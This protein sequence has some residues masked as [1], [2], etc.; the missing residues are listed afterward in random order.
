M[1]M[2]YNEYKEII[3][4]IQPTDNFSSLNAGAFTSKYGNDDVSEK[5]RQR[6]R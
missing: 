1:T 2:K 6:Q 3:T 4:Q 5:H